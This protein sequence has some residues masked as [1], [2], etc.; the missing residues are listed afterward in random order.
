MFLPVDARV[1]RVLEYTPLDGA[2][3]KF[4]TQNISCEVK[5]TD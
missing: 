2:F 4:T 5:R 3:D 1:Y